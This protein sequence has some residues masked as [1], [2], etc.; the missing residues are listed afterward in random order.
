MARAEASVGA[1]VER[2]LPGVL[3]LLIDELEETD[4]LLYASGLAFYAL[5]SV[6]PL[7]IVVMWIVATF[8]GDERVRT[9]AQELARIAPPGLGADKALERV[10]DLG[11]QIGL[12]AVIAALWP[13]TAYGAGLSRAFRRL[14]PD[15]HAKNKAKATGL[16]GR[17]L[18]FLVLL[19]I[20]AIGGI[21]ASYLGTQALGDSVAGIVLGPVVALVAGFL[22]AGAAIALLFRIFPPEPLEGRQI[23]R[24][25][26]FTAGGVSILS[27]GFA[28]Y[29]TFGANFQERYASS[30]VAGIVL[31]AVWLFG[32]NTLLL[33]G[34][35]VALRTSRGK[36]STKRRTRSR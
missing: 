7:V 9:F 27:L 28:L 32:S 33:L 26:V 5:V 15:A 24:G 2:R 12:P 25:T 1:K 17:L 14:A 11:T 16:R 36:G 6:V 31:L 23:L 20:F 30:G 29:L 35:R 19:P 13:A 18:A 22:V 10:A 8:L 4:V 3:R 34:Y 21:V